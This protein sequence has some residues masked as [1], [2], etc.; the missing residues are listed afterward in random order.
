MSSAMTNFALISFNQA[1]CRVCVCVCH[2]HTPT[3]AQEPL[4][5]EACPNLANHSKVRLPR[6]CQNPAERGQEE[7]MEKGS[8]HSAEPLRNERERERVIVYDT[9]TS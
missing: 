8:S 1:L 9:S 6:L 7:E 4:A 2:V 5:N 3:K